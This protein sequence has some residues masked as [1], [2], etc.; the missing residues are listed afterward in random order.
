M[1]YS[2]DEKTLQSFL[3]YLAGRPYAEVHQL[4][5]ALQE[6]IKPLG[7]FPAP[8]EAPVAEAAVETPVQS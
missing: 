5:K 8:T 1:N 2:I 7:P 3:N 4:V 6:N